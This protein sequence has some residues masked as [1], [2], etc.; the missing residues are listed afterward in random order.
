MIEI[1]R[2]SSPTPILYTFQNSKLVNFEWVDDFDRKHGQYASNNDPAITRCAE[3]QLDLLQD[4]PA[5]PVQVYDVRTDLR[6]NVN[7]LWTIL[8]QNALTKPDRSVEDDDI[9][10]F[11]EP[12]TLAVNDAKLFIEKFVRALA[13]R[14]PEKVRKPIG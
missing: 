3:L 11:F 9:G 6:I 7:T 12:H 13:E 4:D 5:R 10:L 8:I 2:V 14:F 1:F